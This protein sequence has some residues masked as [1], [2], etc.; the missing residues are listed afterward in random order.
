MVFAPA[1]SMDT[2]KFED[3][4]IIM[5]NNF[6]LR[7]VR[8]EAKCES[9]E[10]FSPDLDVHRSSFGLHF[11]TATQLKSVNKKVSK[12]VGLKYL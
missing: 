11:Q 6:G 9:V 7:H 4:L 8:E 1:V 3:K 2:I 10:K 5:D 12:Q